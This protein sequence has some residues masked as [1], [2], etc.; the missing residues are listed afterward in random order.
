LP[1]FFNYNAPR[2]QRG[3]GADDKLPGSA[4]IFTIPPYSFPHCVKLTPGMQREASGTY[5]IFW[6]HTPD[7]VNAEGAKRRLS[8][9]EVIPVT[10]GGESLREAGG[11]TVYMNNR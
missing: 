5:L 3:R 10:H 9:P 7:S 4:H 11:L 1:P 8:P 6:L 2:R